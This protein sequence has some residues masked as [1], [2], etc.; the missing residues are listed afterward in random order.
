M[1]ALKKN[2]RTCK[3]LILV[4]AMVLAGTATFAQHDIG[5]YTGIH[6]GFGQFGADVEQKIPT[7]DLTS[8]SSFTYTTYTHQI[9][10]NAFALT[11][12]VGITPFRGHG[13]PLVDKLA[14]EF[15]LAMQFGQ[16]YSWGWGEVA[17][18]E[19]R[20]GVLAKFNVSIADWAN[21]LDTT[22]PAWGDK[23]VTFGGIGFGIPIRTAK[24]SYSSAYKQTFEQYE[25]LGV[26]VDLPDTK[27]TK[28]GFQILMEYGLGLQVNDKFSLNWTIAGLGFIGHFTYSMTIGGNYHFK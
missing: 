28:G 14:F 12:V 16:K 4:V 7:Y 8:T 6:L 21:L 24:L 20:P 15:S 23:L 5:V 19:I 22:S 2:L 10:T 26:K 1:K 13:K 27:T 9:R 18:T 25:A 3:S 17:T 11:P